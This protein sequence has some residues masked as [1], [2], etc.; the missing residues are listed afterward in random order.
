M[1]KMSVL[2]W[3]AFILVIIGGLNWGLVGLLNL[4]LVG[5]LFGA[6]STVARVVY[7]LVGLGAVYMLIGAFMKPKM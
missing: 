6:M 1:K 4:D 5:V 2:G 7:V 3:I